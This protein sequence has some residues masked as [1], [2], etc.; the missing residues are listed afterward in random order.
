MGIRVG[1]DEIANVDVSVTVVVPYTEHVLN[2]L[3]LRE[4]TRRDLLVF[5]RDIGEDFCELVESPRLHSSHEQVGWKSP[6]LSGFDLDC[7]AIEL[8]ESTMS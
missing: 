7:A 6:V 5:D 2:N 4:G 3:Q 8:I 1:V